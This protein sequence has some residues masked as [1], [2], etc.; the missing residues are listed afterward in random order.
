MTGIFALL[1]ASLSVATLDE[2]AGFAKVVRDDGGTNQFA[3]GGFEETTPPWKADKHSQFGRFGMN[4]GG[5]FRVWPHAKNRVHEFPQCFKFELGRK[6]IYS[7]CV[8]GHGEAWAMA[9]WEST[10]NGQYADNNWGV[11]K[12]KLDGGWIRC[13]VTV[14]PKTPG[15]R[16]DRLFLYLGINGEDSTAW[17]NAENYVDCDNLVFRED[18]PEWHFHNMW[19]THDA[20][21]SDNARV[22]FSS[23]FAGPWLEPDA[24]PVTV[25][26]LLSSDGRPLGVRTVEKP[27]RVFTVDFGRLAYEGTGTCQV[28]LYD[29]KNRLEAGS[30]TLRVRIRPTPM[31]GPNDIFIDE[32]GRV[33]LGGKPF[34][35]LGFFSA[36]NERNRYPDPKREIPENLRKLSAAGFNTLVEYSSYLLKSKADADWFYGLCETNGIRILGDDFGYGTAP[37]L[38]WQ[39]TDA[40][41]EQVRA[42]ANRP[43]VIGFFT[44]DEA[45]YDKIPDLEWLRRALNEEAPGKVVWPCNVLNAGPFAGCGD[46]QGGDMYPF[47]INDTLEGTDKNLAER[48]SLRPAAAWYAPQCYNWSDPKLP[49]GEY[50]KRGGEANFEQTLSIALMMAAQGVNGFFFY[51]LHD[52]SACPIKEWIPRRWEIMCKC[53]TE[54][55]RLE[56]FITSG[57]PI[58]PLPVTVRKGRVRAVTMRDA[59]GGVRILIV[60]LQKDNEATFAL[61]PGVRSFR[62]RLGRT[63]QADNTCVF[64]GPAYSCDILECVF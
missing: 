61:P 15:P 34:M 58:E 57:R 14:M 18:V 56:P 33:T 54:L 28:T 50:A 36:L 32:A 60:S 55:R 5:G 21:Y 17:T 25:L 10:V 53:A 19:P 7:V 20:V 49:P 11:K 51:S 63:K 52:I 43:S 30:K 64:A 3:N 41:K 13:D 38:K 46:V 8:R 9:A 6:Y 29:R 26:K 23:V 16:S 39:K 62:S 35:P 12:T 59:K 44:M 37:W 31:P 27:G 4:G 22:R 1:L 2:F 40:F 42:L 24:D 48:M 45:T 47:G